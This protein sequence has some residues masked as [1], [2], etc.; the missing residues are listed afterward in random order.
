MTLSLLAQGSK[1]SKPY[2]PAT[3]T[4]LS[5]FTW[6]TT[7]FPFS[8]FSQLFSLQVAAQPLLPDSYFRFSTFKKLTV[9]SGFSYKAQ[10]CGSFYS[11][12]DERGSFLQKKIWHPGL[13]TL[14]GSR[15]IYSTRLWTRSIITGFCEAIARQ[16]VIA[17]LNDSAG[18]R[19]SFYHFIFEIFYSEF[20]LHICV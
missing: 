13:T 18:Q 7:S 17:L 2:F 6:F 19:K 20:R 16:S 3:C 15:W 9:A 1:I 11:R 14:L 5:M 10:W 12:Q 8:Y 4:Q